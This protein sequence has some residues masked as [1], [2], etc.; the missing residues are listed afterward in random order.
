[1]TQQT[2]LKNK[3]HNV[4]NL[5]A[6]KQRKNSHRN[7]C[8]PFPSL[9]TIESLCCDLLLAVDDNFPSTQGFIP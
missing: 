7:L 8:S 1:M 4:H 9:L 3:T 6:S 5:Q 2:L